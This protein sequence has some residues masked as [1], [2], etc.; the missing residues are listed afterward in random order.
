MYPSS[1]RFVRGDHNGMIFNQGNGPGKRK[2]I[3]GR[4]ILINS[5]NFWYGNEQALSADYLRKNNKD[6]VEEYPI[7]SCSLDQ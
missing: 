6:W 7:S 1:I 2:E 3:N 5:T 4:I